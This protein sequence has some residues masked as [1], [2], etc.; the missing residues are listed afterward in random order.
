LLGMAIDTVI[1]VCVTF[2]HA[3]TMEHD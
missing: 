2:N 3:W 1:R